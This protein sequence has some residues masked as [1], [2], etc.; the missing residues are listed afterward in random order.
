MSTAEFVEF[1]TAQKGRCLRA[2][3]A[4]GMDP[5]RAEEAVAEAFARA[6]SRWR[7][8]RVMES[9]AAWVVRTA[10]NQNVSW[11]RQ[12]RRE[13]PSESAADL[14][15][16]DGPGQVDLVAAIRRLP[17][18][19]REVVVLRYLLDLDTHATAR[20]MGV[21]PGTVS[22]HLHRALASL[23]EHLTISEGTPS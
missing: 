23:R 3:V 15:V 1:Y 14:P 4:S 7:T 10:I 18:R 13:V 20:S 5:D 22:A 16:A 8:V 9:P 17:P 6:W 2:A 12:R 21:A 11:W 19:Q